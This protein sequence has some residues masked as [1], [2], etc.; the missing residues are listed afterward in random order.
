MIYSTSNHYK[1][2]PAPEIG[3]DNHTYQFNCS[4][5]K[6]TQGTHL[7]C[8]PQ[9]LAASQA[10]T[11]RESPAHQVG[12]TAAQQV[13]GGQASGWTAGLTHQQK[14]L[15]GTRQGKHPAGWWLP[16]PQGTGRGQGSGLTADT[17]QLQSHFNPRLAL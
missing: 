2:T 10:E 13:D 14:S 12:L 17:T 1:V 16:Q 3:E 4:P 6:C 5:S 8:Q 9:P 15:K 11:Q 7:L